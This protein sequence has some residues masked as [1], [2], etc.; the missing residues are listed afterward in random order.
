MRISYRKWSQYPYQGE[1][2]P[3]QPSP[4][5]AYFPM[6]FIF[7]QGNDEFL[8][9][10]RQRINWQIKNP[11]NIDWARELSIVEQTLSVLTPAQTQLAQYWGTAESTQ[12]MLPMIFNLARKYR[13][14]SPQ[15]ARVLGYFH[16]AV[17]DAFVISWHFKYLWDVARPNQYGQ[18]L[19]PILVTPRFPSY[20]SAHAT[21]AGC[22]ESILTYFFPQEASGIR[23][24]ME[25]CALSRLYAGVHFKVDN[26]EGLR[27]GRQIGNI[28]V[29]VLRTQNLNI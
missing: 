27:L 10:F 26:D 15:I 8:D 25:E 11:E 9:P 29:N 6:F 16:A 7:R 12:N 3:P 2:F 5:P 21:V 23:K 17:N 20:P 22:A 14:G 28:V 1:Q 18:N 24:T 13:L 19:T 4:A